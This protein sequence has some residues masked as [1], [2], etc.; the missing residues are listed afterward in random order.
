MAMP[1][2]DPPPGVPEWVVTYGDMMSLLLTFFIMLVSMAEMKS[3]G[4]LRKMMDSVS[5]RFGPTEGT[6]GSP[7]PV[8]SDSSSLPYQASKGSSSEGGTEKSG[9]ETGGLAGPSR[10]VERIGDG[11][12]ITLGGNATFERFEADLPVAAR[13]DLE[14]IAGVIGNRPNRIVVRGHATRER[15]PVDSPYADAMEL[16]F[17]RAAAGAAY[18]EELGID[19]QRIAVVAAGDSEPRVVTRDAT[20]QAQN[21]RIDVF[22]I[23]EYIT[24]AR[25]ARTGAP[26]G[27]R[28]GSRVHTRTAGTP[29][30][31]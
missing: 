25:D 16:S 9:L 27:V 1:P 26:S 12:Q 17:A 13:K 19:R 8:F 2:D 7:G 21:R 3:E 23:D 4:K 20:R 10:T 29:V 28:T 24:P 15:L 31:R 5:E 11:T 22:I 30:Y 18:L 6:Y 14:T